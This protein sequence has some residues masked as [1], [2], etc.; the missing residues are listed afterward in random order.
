MRKGWTKP[1]SWTERDENYVRRF[2]PIRPLSQ[3]GKELRRTASSIKARASKLKLSKGRRRYSPKE[4]RL[5][6]EQYPHIS[7]KEISNLLNRPVHSIYRRAVV[8]LGLR[9]TEEYLQGPAAC[10]L[11]RGDNVGAACRFLPG[12][13]PANKGLRRPGYSK[14]HGRMADTTFKKGHPPRNYLPIGTIKANTD[15]YLRIKVSGIPNNGHG[16]K[17]RNWEFVHKRVWEATHGPIPKGH[18]IWWKDGNH[19]NCALENLELLTD[20][21]HMARTSIHTL[22]AEL[23]STIVWAGALKRRIRRLERD[24]EQTQRSAESPVRDHRAAQG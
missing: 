9:K 16:A 24:K 3:L 22:P 15:G 5:L 20:K 19:E 11:R 8:M 17:D 21:D 14:L 2:Y 1:K 23:K 13:V 12:H 18:R 4:D 6:R 7:T 10:R